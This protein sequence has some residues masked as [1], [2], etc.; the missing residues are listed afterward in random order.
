MKILEIISDTNIGGAGILLFNRLSCTN[1]KKYQTAVVLPRGSALYERFTGLGVRC[2]EVECKGDISFDVC[3]IKKY[4]N[5]IKRELPDI[6]NTHGV[7]SARIAAYCLRVPV[8]IC[9]RHCVFPITAKE[10]MLGKLNNMLSDWFIAVAYSAKANLMQMGIERDKISVI[11]NG[12]EA[13]KV[14]DSKQ[15]A[16]IRQSLNID[17]NTI[18]LSFCARL[19]VC[20]GH[21]YFLETL[22]RLCDDGVDVVALLIGDGSQ[23]KKLRALCK[24]YKIES[25]VIFCGFVSDISPLMNIADININC[26]V[27]TETSS[28]ALSEGMSLGLPA[29]VSDYGG[30]PYMIKHG[31]N[32]FVCRQRDSLQMAEYIKI[33]INDRKLY[34]KMSCRA[35]ARFD[36]ELNAA[37]MTE[38][39]NRLY[40]ELY[41]HRAKC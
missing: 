34:E 18:V 29:V 10:K 33:L 6:I 17:K 40:D 8:K 23:R 22:K 39:T 3:S 1:L 24:K 7:L 35:R 19:E 20:K 32:G 16:C 14:L 11:I 25:R 41:R 27:G 2:I 37:A 9:T 5:I 36:S 30:N 26:S 12:A 21:E 38:K 15:R 13:L 4:M 31:E 28:L